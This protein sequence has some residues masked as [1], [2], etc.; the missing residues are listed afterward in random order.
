MVSG[1]LEYFKKGIFLFYI[2]NKGAQSVYF[3]LELEYRPMW[4]LHLYT[5]HEEKWQISCGQ[6]IKKG[7]CLNFLRTTVMMSIFEI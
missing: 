2:L 5:G 6:N 7:I 1:P 4:G 3:K